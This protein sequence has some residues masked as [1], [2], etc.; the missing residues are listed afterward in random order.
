M[1]YIFVLS[2][3]HPLHVRELTVLCPL[4]VR[5][6]CAFYDFRDDFHHRI[7]IFLPFFCPFGVRYLYLL[8]CDST[9]TAVLSFLKPLDRIQPNLK[10]DLLILA[11]IASVHIFAQSH[12]TIGPRKW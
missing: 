11:R 9:I 3:I 10:S 8:M 6:V 1:R 4:L 12:P 7:N 2:I 5:Y